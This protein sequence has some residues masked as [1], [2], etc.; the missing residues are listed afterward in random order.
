MTYGNVTSFW[1]N[2]RSVD[3]RETMANTA[4]VKSERVNGYVMFHI[5]I[6][7]VIIFIIILVIVT[8]FIVIVII[9]VIIVII[10]FSYSQKN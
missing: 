4:L 2:T 10:N 9:T 7:I 8:F 6:G 5:V 3:L 1:N